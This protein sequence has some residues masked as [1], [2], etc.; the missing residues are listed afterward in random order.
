MKKPLS[1]HALPVATNVDAGSVHVAVV[2]SSRK[3]SMVPL[4][5]SGGVVTLQEHVQAPAP[6]AGADTTSVE[7]HP[8]GH[9]DIP[10]ASETTVN[11]LG[12]VAHAEMLQVVLVSPVPVSLVP[13][14]VPLPP[15][16]R[17]LEVGA[18]PHAMCAQASR[19]RNDR[20]IQRIYHSTAQRRSPNT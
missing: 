12:M 3:R 18:P 13:V 1:V 16:P 20:R 19:R 17:R 2:P 6:A 10:L 11:P 7:V 14:S 8:L 5:Q 15:S 9:A 4:L